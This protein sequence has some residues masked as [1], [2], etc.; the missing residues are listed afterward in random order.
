MCF[1]RRRTFA[2]GAVRDS[3]APTSVPPRAR[4]VGNSALYPQPTARRTETRACPE[5]RRDRVP[6]TKH[7]SAPPDRRGR[8]PTFARSARSLDPLGRVLPAHVR[9]RSWSGDDRRRTPAAERGG[10]HRASLAASG[11]GPARDPRRDPLRLRAR[12]RPGPGTQVAQAIASR[13]ISCSLPA[14]PG[15]WRSRA[16]NGS[17]YPGLRRLLVHFDGY[18]LSAQRALVDIAYTVGLEDL[19]RFRNLIGACERGD[20]ATAAEHCHR[21][22]A[23]QIRNA[24]TQALFL[25][26]AHA[27]SSGAFVGKNARLDGG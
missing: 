20:F 12:A 5:R 10:R 7:R 25:E 18:P 2:L 4:R 11:D 6:Q 13:R 22:A 16:W 26:A 21:R 9:R 24:A 17:C 27:S 15:R 8:R 23:R 14:W 3:L 19:A 1:R